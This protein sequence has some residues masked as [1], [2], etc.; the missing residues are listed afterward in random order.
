MPRLSHEKHL[1]YC[2]QYYLKN[3]EKLKRLAVLN[4]YKH[5]AEIDSKLAI[6]EYREKKKYY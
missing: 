1:E 5:K 2:R 3:R 4:Y 6:Q